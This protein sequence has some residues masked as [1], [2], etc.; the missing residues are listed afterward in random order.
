MAGVYRLRVVASAAGA[1]TF[2]VE[3]PDGV[4]IGRGTV[5][6]AFS[7]G[8]LAFTLAAGAT[9]FVVEDEF[10]ITVAAGS[11]KFTAMTAT[12]I[13][14]SQIPAAILF[15]HTDATNGDTYCTIITRLA[16]VNASELLWDASVNAGAQTAALAALAT[17]SYIIAR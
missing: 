13:D 4:D 12:A 6:V 15:G 9:D 5:G 10:T 2:I 14:G 7:A 16:E 3:N 11:G 8:G 1:G 17:T